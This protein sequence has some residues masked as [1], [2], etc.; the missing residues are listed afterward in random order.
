MV[1]VEV[2]THPER[3]ELPGLRRHL[4]GLLV[5]APVADVANALRGQEVGG[6][7]RLLKVG[8]G[9]TDRALARSLL[10][11]LDRG[12]D[13]LPLLVFRHADM[14]DAPARETVRDELGVA[15]L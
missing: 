10:D 5:V 3:V 12:A 11:R 4:V 8:A 15:L 9:P 1:I 7:R 14:D 6:V 13:I 2:G